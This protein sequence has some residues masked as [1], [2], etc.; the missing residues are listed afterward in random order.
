MLTFS[1]ARQVLVAVAG[2]V[3]GLAGGLTNNGK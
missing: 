3:K 1:S 2:M